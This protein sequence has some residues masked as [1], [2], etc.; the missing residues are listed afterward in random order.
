[1]WFT[2]VWSNWYGLFTS[3]RSPY[4]RTGSLGDGGGFVMLE[5]LEKM[6]KGG[7]EKMLCVSSPHANAPDGQKKVLGREC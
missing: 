1:M 7:A 6:M 5:M 2:N 4:P 3:G